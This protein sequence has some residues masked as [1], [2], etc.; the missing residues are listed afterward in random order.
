MQRLEHFNTLFVGR[1]D[2]NSIRNKFEMIAETLTNLDIFLISESKIDSS[3]PNMQ[4]KINGYKLFRRD[5]NRFGGGLMLYL[6]KEIPCKF[7]NNHPIVPNAE[8]ICIEFQKL[9]RKWLLLG[10]YKPPTHN[11]LEFIASITKIVGFYLQNFENFFIIGD[12]NM[13]P[14]NV[15]LNDLLQFYDLTAFIKEPTCYQSQNPNCIDQF[16]TNGK[17]LFKHC[18]TFETGFSD[19]HKLISA[20]MKSGIFKGPSKKKIYQSYKKSDHECFSSALR[21]ELENLEGDT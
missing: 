21:E 16:L 12:L 17:S 11:D 20:I 8:I 18:Q 4:F 10:C 14:E 13:T 6:N 2:I 1:L 15:H 5:C 3:F 19:H 9:K 7:L